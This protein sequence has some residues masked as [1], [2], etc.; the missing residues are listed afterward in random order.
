MPFDIITWL[1]YFG[2]TP[3]Q[4]TP[5]LIFAMFAV[6]Y[7]G[8]KF[9][10]ILKSIKRITNSIVEIQTVFKIAGVPLDHLLTE[11]PGSPLQPTGVGI[12]YIRE[13]GLEKILDEKKD[14]L[15]QKLKGELPKDYTDY[16]V[17]ET[18]RKVLL[19]L[20]DDPMMK[21]IKDYAFK[22]ALEVEII[23][24]TGALWLRDDFLGVPRGVAKKSE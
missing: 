9:N 13:S 14:V 16:D 7:L 2:I 11:G 12:N 22:N 17:Q 3:A 8:F 20:R 23:L 15:L 6:I 18:S 4:V 10:P 21:P 1:T 24:R 19:S 5:L